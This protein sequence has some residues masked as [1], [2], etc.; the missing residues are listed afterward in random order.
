MAVDSIL[1]VKIQ[2]IKEH[3]ITYNLNLQIP[4]DLKVKDN[5]ILDVSAILGNLLDNAI[6]AVLRIGKDKERKI[7][8]VIQYNNG[9][10]IFN[11][12]N[13]SNQILT[14]FTHILIRSE[15][16]KERYGIG[17]SSIK[18]RV[19]RLKGYYD[20]GYEGGQYTALIVIPIENS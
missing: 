14:D 2:K 12:Q 7:D 18:E 5:N 16:G 11:L 6:E 9:K 15:K 13:T 1:N 19:D 20:F 3:G 17:I 4:S 8:I 10:L